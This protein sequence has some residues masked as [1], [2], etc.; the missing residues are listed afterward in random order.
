M[1]GVVIIIAYNHTFNLAILS[2][3]GPGPGIK[4][5]AIGLG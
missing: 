2:Y 5:I 3:H 1:P 4:L